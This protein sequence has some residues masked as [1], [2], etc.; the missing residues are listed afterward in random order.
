MRIPMPSQGTK[1]KHTS[2]DTAGSTARRTLS[3][4]IEQCAK[5]VAALIVATEQQK[6]QA[7]MAGDVAT[8]DALNARAIQFAVQYGNLARHQLQILD[9]TVMKQLVQGFVKVNADIKAAITQ[10]QKATAFANTVTAIAK[11]VDG[12]ITSALVK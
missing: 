5:N 2:T 1:S 6:T 4:Q 8:A 10:V 3:S 9:D 7:Q 11:V 12:L